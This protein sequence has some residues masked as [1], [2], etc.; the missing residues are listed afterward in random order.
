MYCTPCLGNDNYHR[1]YVQGVRTGGTYRGYV[2]HRF[3]SISQECV[4][5]IHCTS[6][7]GIARVECE[8]VVFVT[9]ILIS[10]LHTRSDYVKLDM[11]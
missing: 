9:I 11:I 7:N 3:D 6:P 8:T 10:E 4:K 1:G 2:Q 5:I